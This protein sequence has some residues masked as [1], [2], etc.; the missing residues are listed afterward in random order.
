M[1][2]LLLTWS[3]QSSSGVCGVR[4]VSNGSAV[5]GD[6]EVRRL[7]ANWRKC[8]LLAFE[9]WYWAAIGG[10]AGRA[11][12]V[13]VSPRGWRGRDALAM[14][15]D[16]GT[17]AAAVA[18]STAAAGAVDGARIRLQVEG[19]QILLLEI[20]NVFADFGRVGGRLSRKGHFA[21][22]WPTYH[23][24]LVLINSYILKTYFNVCTTPLCIEKA[25][26]IISH[27]YGSI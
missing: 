25:L 5:A 8:F 23:R 26:K 6:L 9:V 27:T 17:A 4:V 16:T 22:P 19:L 15:Q 12:G 24:G 20:S 10:D 3:T 13:A 1:G 2:Y 18:P 11:A 7:K 21:S 14:R